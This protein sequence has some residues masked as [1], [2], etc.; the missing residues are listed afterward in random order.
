MGAVA[1]ALGQGSTLEYAGKSWKLSPWTY[2]IQGRFE[3]FLEDQ[4]LR[5]LQRQTALMPPTEAA[6]YRKAHWEMLAT[7]S[8][9]F[10]SLML[11]EA[12][13]VRDNI[14][15]LLWLQLQ[16]NH[17]EASVELAREMCDEMPDKVMEAM[18]A[19]NPP[20]PGK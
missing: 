1:Q 19:A 2:E 3:E 12:L 11:W 4:A 10:G 5:R 15:H 17:P 16:A 13:K 6:E 8:C 9:S 18:T 14:A 7:R 20:K